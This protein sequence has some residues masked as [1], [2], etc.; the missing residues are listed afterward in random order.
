[1]DRTLSSELSGN[2][3]AHLC[4]DKPAE[5][6]RGASAEE[7]EKEDIQQALPGLT[8]ATF[9]QESDEHGEIR[10]QNIVV[11]LAR[12]Q[13]SSCALPNTLWALACP[14]SLDLTRKRWPMATMADECWARAVWLPQQHENLGLVAKHDGHMSTQAT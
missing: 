11:R 3:R 4:K 13:M 14:A 6:I 10:C 7:S 1:M 5:S 9:D 8:V 12:T 2:A